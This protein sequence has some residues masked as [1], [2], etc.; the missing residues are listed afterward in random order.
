M[1][2]DVKLIERL[3]RRFKGVPNFDEDDAIELVIE[4][5]EAHESDASDELILLY[6]QVQGA[7]QIAFGAAHYFK[8]TDGEESVD[9]SM[10]AENYRKLA[11]E[12]QTEYDRERGKFL[13]NNFRVMSRIDRPRTTPPT[14]ESGQL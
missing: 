4:A 5:K 13:G 8:F 1:A 14:G 3:L 7:W 2:D 11:R 9:K 6:A 10:V 12:L